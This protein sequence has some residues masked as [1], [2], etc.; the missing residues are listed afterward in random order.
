MDHPPA[1]PP[2]RPELER[3]RPLTRADETAIETNCA[4][5]CSVSISS[6]SAVSPPPGEPV[7]ITNAAYDTLTADLRDEVK[8]R[9]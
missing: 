2:E 8:T 9:P 6:R 3:M 5:A 1:D 7:M 4:R